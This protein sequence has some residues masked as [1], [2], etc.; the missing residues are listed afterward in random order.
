MSAELYFNSI[1]EMPFFNWRKC[2]EK[3]AY[4]FCRIDPK[5]GDKES[6]VKAWEKIY[7]SYLLE[8]GLGKDYERIIELQKEIAELQ[9][10]FVISGDRFIMNKIRE[11]K[12]E[13]KE[14]IERPIETDTD[15]ILN[16]LRKWMNHWIDT[17]KITVREFYKLI[18]D[19]R[20]EIEIQK[21][22]K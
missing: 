18:R 4:Q 1:D 9:C 2:Q 19:Y 17:K 5:K 13:L 21:K 14:L 15:T 7:D 22:A 20:R 12:N 11:L 6:D 3:Q 8:F 16:Y 10:D